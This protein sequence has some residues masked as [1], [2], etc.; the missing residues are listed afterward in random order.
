MKSQPS[1]AKQVAE[2]R[3]DLALQQSAGAKAHIVSSSY[4]MTK[5]M[6]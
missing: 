5:V 6:P 3:N 1:A 2:K 4:G